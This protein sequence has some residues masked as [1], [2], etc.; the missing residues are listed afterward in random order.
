M[1]AILSWHRPH[2][3]RKIVGYKLQAGSEG[4][5]FEGIIQACLR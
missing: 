4:K 2:R 5:V 3:R 1:P